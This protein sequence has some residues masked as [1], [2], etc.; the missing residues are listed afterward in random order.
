MKRFRNAWLSDTDDEDVAA[1]P[2]EP[3]RG[4]NS[5]SLHLARVGAGPLRGRPKKHAAKH[6]RWKALQ[7][8]HHAHDLTYVAAEGIPQT[9]ADKAIPAWAQSLVLDSAIPKGL[10]AC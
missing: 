1:S 9:T 6:L 5:M 8:E 7:I 2:V 10:I 4:G 3:P